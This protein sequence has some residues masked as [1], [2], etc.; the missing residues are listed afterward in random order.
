[1]D[2]WFQLLDVFIV[3][4]ALP[5][6]RPPLLQM[7]TKH[8]Q[9]LERTGFDVNQF[10]ES[11]P[12]IEDGTGTEETENRGDFNKDDVAGSFQEARGRASLNYRKQ[13]D[14]Q[15]AEQRAKNLLTV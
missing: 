15:Q 13:K 2:T 8:L 7:R 14:E 6:L 4:E 12:D 1:M 10:Y 11:A 3:N 5:Q 9:Q